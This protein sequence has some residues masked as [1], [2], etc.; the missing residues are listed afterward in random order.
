MSDDPSPQGREG[1]VP[2]RLAGALHAWWP[3]IR[4]LVSVGLLTIVISGVDRERALGVLTSAR[5]ELIFLTWV[6]YLLGRFFAAARWFLLV[7]AIDPAVRYADLVRLSFIGMF[8]QFFPA[9]AIAL[10]VGRVYGLSRTTD[11][12]AGSFASVLAE[13][14]FGLLAL[15]ILALVGLAF[16]PPGVPPVLAEL[17]WI[18]FMVVAV[19]CMG[20]TSETVRRTIGS[21]LAK[22][23][24][25]GVGDRLRKLY[26]RL[27]LMR[28]SPRLMVLSMVAALLNTAFRI[29]PAW[30]VALALGIAV[31]PLQLFIIVPIIVFATQIPI[32]AGG[33]GV[34]EVGWVALLGIIGVPA[35]DAIVMSLLLVAIIFVAALPGAWYYA[36]HGLAAPDEAAR[37]EE[38]RGAGHPGGRHPGGP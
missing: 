22:L 28:G 14:V 37:A 24:L 8:L 10:E 19:G 11:D 30:L 15:T 7:R 26:D 1:S 2:G 18:G 9:G 17:A 16:A 27:D 20:L 3:R 6:T 4:V 13:R 33:L 25:G 21:L 36:R 12:L 38:A 23:G 29:V 34:R 5:L 35:A 32:S 31:S